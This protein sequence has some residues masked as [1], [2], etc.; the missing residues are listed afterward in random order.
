MDHLAGVARVGAFV[1][2]DTG[3]VEQPKVANGA[4]EFLLE[5][6]DLLV[7]LATFVVRQGNGELF[8]SQVSRRRVWI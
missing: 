7:F 3:F 4:S 1:S 6:C 8:E 2:S 5:L